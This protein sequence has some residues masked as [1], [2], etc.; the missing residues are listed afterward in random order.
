MATLPPRKHEIHA[1]QVKVTTSGIELESPFSLSA[2]QFS[3]LKISQSPLVLFVCRIDVLAG[4][5]PS[6]AWFILIAIFLSF[7]LVPL[8]LVTFRSFLKSCVT[9]PRLKHYNLTFIS[10]V[11]KAPAFTVKYSSLV[12]AAKSVTDQNQLP[13]VLCLY[14]LP[15]AS[16]YQLCLTSRLLRSEVSLSPL[17]RSAAIYIADPNRH[18]S[19][20]SITAKESCELKAV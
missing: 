17:K 8:E 10:L 5:S 12:F 9:P 13:R 1:L 18:C 15:P 16:N 4:Y 2:A 19:M 14:P 11:Y 3:F 20:V 6:L 7:S